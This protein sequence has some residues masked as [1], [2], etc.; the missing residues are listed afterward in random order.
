MPAQKA[1]D[2]KDC[3]HNGWGAA[4]ECWTYEVGCCL[5]CTFS[6]PWTVITSTTIKN[7]FVK[8]GFSADR[9]GSNDDRVMKLAEDK[10]NA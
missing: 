4:P 9:I 3:S 2:F 7:C 6:E 8:R 10:E 1:A 5:Q